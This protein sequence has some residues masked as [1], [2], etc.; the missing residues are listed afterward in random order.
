[1]ISIDIIAQHAFL[2]SK[3]NNITLYDSFQ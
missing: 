2:V 1:L 3:I